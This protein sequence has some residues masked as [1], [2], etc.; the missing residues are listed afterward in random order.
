VTIKENIDVRPIDDDDFNWIQSIGVAYH[1]YQ[2]PILR[3]Q[4]KFERCG[5]TLPTCDAGC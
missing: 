1:I 3:F 2:A 4:N 5:P